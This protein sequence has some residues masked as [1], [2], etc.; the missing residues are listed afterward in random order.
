MSGVTSASSL[1]IRGSAVP[2]RFLQ[3]AS[4]E[5]SRDV[6]EF[7][8][9]LAWYMF[10]V[11]CCVIPTVCAYRRRRLNEFRLREAAAQRRSGQDLT[12]ADGGLVFLRGS[13]TDGRPIT[14]VASQGDGRRILAEQ[15]ERIK[16]ERIK[17]IQECLARTTMIV[18]DNDLM[19]RSEEDVSASTTEKEKD[20]ESANSQSKDTSEVE[21]YVL[22]D[23]TAYLDETEHE[24]AALILPSNNEQQKCSMV[25]SKLPVQNGSR[26]VPAA[27][28]I[29]LCPYENG[30]SVT[31]S[32]REQCQ[33][34]FHTECIV[35]WLTKK[36]EALCP[37][38]RQEFCTVDSGPEALA[39]QITRG[40]LTAR[41]SEDVIRDLER[42]NF[43]L[44]TT[45]E[46]MDA[47]T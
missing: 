36:D 31:W 7:V 20:G 16:E 30:D 26:N 13:T 25:E 45:A 35:P 41:S 22:S 6:Y 38:C 37:C 10:L 3:Q 34:A 42:G 33:H 1:F 2:L 44:Q 28:A 29:C 18:T 9:F 11:L 32:P 12:G 8:A 4:E 19:K 40:S 21:E 23:V 15:E 17:N 27:C 43:S 5:D 14:I 39:A 24:F 47:T 46:L